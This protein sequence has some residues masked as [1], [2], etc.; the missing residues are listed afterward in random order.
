MKKFILLLL[1][2]TLLFSSCEKAAKY[3]PIAGEYTVKCRI[4]DVEYDISL[5]LDENLSGKLA[6]SPESEMC[7]WEFYY[8]PEDKSIKYFTSL[9]EVSEAKNENVKYLFKFVLCDF[10]NI[11]D[12]S[13]SKISGLDVSVLKTTDG[14]VIYTD[15]ASGRP[16]RIEVG[17]MT[18]DIILAPQ[19]E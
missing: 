9:G 12:V 1:M 17:D 18:A 7:D 3:T 2:F 19:S 13:H 5:T 10:D 4:S 16:L 15:S 14:A 11:A 6:F 8:S